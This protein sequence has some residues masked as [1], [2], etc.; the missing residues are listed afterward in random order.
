MQILYFTAAW[1]GPCKMFKPTLEATLS[2]M[3]LSA[4]IVDVDQNPTLVQKYSITGVPTLI[5]ERENIVV[6]RNS[7]VMS[8]GQLKQVFSNY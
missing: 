3:G 8:K 4:Q 2:E 6:Y 5:L 1:C 7:G